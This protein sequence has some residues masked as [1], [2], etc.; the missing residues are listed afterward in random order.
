MFF[1][2][3]FMY[4]ALLFSIKNNEENVS[5]IAAYKLAWTHFMEYW[6]I[7]L[8]I[9]SLLF[10]G[11]IFFIIPAIILA[12]WFSVSLMVY[13]VEDIKGMDALLM[14]K[15]YIQGYWSS[16][17]LRLAF[18]SIT[19]CLIC[20][21]LFLMFSK[22]LTSYIF[23]IYLLLITV[24]IL[25]VA[26][27]YLFLIYGNL[28]LLKPKTTELIEALNKTKEV[29]IKLKLLKPAFV[30]GAVIGLPLV[31]IIF[32]LCV[33]R[34]FQISGNSMAPAFVDKELITANIW[35]KKTNTYKRGDV[36]VFYS[37]TDNKKV[38]IKRIIGLPD[39]KFRITQGEVYINDVKLD[40][41][42]YL[43][44]EIKT[45]SGE[46]L[47]ENAS[48]KLPLRHYVVLGDN[49]SLN[50]DSR[51][52]GFIRENDIIA[53]AGICFWNCPKN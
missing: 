11:K 17:F 10:I 45:L 52:W 22:N 32:Y 41:N 3:S 8:I 43:N 30:E 53:I 35:R 44:P 26:S 13:L 19:I 40:E 31:L 9:F 33:V 48:F 39:D 37:P 34:I 38:L 2:L 21:P 14:S 49:R 5:L 7:L 28:R 29:K 42:T 4:L 25:P 20:F 27:T 18:L 46:F 23:E 12:V 50:D 36:V 16:V 6:K 24:F 47:Q 51:N 15:Q 1:V